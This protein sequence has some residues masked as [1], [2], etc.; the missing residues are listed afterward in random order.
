[1]S[2]FAK[3]PILVINLDRRVDRW[4]SI[5]DHLLS[6]EFVN[7]IESP[8]RISA[9]DDSENPGR[10]CSESHKK[11]LQF[12]KEKKWESVLILE[13]DARLRPNF[14]TSYIQMM[15]ELPKNWILIFLGPGRANGITYHSPHLLRMRRGSDSNH[16]TGTHAVLYHRRAYELCITALSDLD[17]SLV[18]TDL[19][20]SNHSSSKIPPECLFVSVPY[21]A[22]FAANSK[23][24]IRS[25][26]NENDDLELLLDTE[27]RL[28]NL[29][30]KYEMITQK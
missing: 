16:L 12:A 1:M 11:C 23:S 26:V 15:S 2:S 6:E 14:E 27:N 21:L 30:R 3:I 20:L 4:E 7:M 9:V 10:G 25:R 22:D 18:H 17:N 28:S 8:T 24:D 19:I 5:Q 29:M 13:D